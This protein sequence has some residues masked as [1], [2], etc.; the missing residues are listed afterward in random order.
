MPQSIIPVM[1]T[2]CAAQQACR[3]NAGYVAYS[4]SG[5]VLLVY[6]LSAVAALTAMRPKRAAW[7]E[8]MLLLRFFAF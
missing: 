3:Y 6:L 2:A 4:A 7:A 1:K 5:Q 8:Q